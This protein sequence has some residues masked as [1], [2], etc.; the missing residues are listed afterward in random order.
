MRSV[1]R[2]HAGGFDLV[3]TRHDPPAGVVPHPDV[4]VLFFNAGHMPREGHAGII[5]RM[6]DRAAAQGLVTWRFDLPGLGDSPGD[7]PVALND[8]FLA[9]HDGVHREAAVELILALTGPD[10]PG[11]L[12]L[13]GLCGGAATALMA[14]LKEPDRVAGLVALEAEFL[15]PSA[16]DAKTLGQKLLSKA[17]WL[18]LLTGYSR[19][20]G[21]VRLPAR[22]LLRMLGS[23]LLPRDTN[24]QLVKAWRRLVASEVPVFVAMA[25]GGRRE[26]FYKQLNLLLLNGQG[27]SSVTNLSIAG[28]NHILASGDGPDRLVSGIEAW[29]RAAF[30]AN[31]SNDSVIEPAAT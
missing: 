23:R 1:V 29:V 19:Y 6:A 15:R 30:P 7:L 8:F 17:S 21:R 2:I 31:P 9:V 13:G 28:T 26:A 4:G 16:V 20:S 12:V 25:S 11:R 22:M 14:A 3:G 18:R 24:R 5:A 27:G 10:G